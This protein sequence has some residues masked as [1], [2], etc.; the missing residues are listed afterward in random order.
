M[1]STL[2]KT[3]TRYVARH[4]DGHGAGHFCDKKFDTHGEAQAEIDS[5]MD[6]VEKSNHL[7]YWKTIGEN[8]YITK[9]TILEER[10]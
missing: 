9:Q 4:A 7:V 2:P 5:C 1:N 8:M 10:V 3:T 6:G